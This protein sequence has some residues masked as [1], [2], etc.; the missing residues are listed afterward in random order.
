MVKFNYE[1]I[2]HKKQLSF[3]RQAIFYVFL[4]K[5]VFINFIKYELNK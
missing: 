1:N 2:V 3:R 4:F 5:Q